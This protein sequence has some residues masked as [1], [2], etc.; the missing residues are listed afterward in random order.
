MRAGAATPSEITALG[1]RSHSTHAGVARP[2]IAA[3]VAFSLMILFVATLL[4][5][6]FDRL[7]AVDLGFQPDRLALL[8]VETR[9]RLEPAEAR[10]LQRQLLARV[11]QL[12]EVERASM[13]MW[14]LFRGWSSGGN[15]DVPG[16]G[17]V[18]FHRLSV[19]PQF[20]QAMGTRLID[21]R[22]F[23][24]RDSDAVNPVPVIVNE[25]FA[26]KFL[27][28]GIAVG[29][30]LQT[31]ISGQPVT[32][33]IVGLVGDVRDGAVRGEMKPFVF[34]PLADA[35]GTLVVRSS[36]DVRTVADRVRAELPRIHPSLRLV[37][38]TTQNALVGSTLLRERLLAVLSAFFA[39]LGLALA[40]VGLYG[41]SSHAVLRRTRE[42]GIRV[43][44]GARPAAILRS[45]LGRV[46]V[47]VA[48]GTVV[49]LAGGL[50]FA[51]F[52]GTLLYEVE[53]L[54]ASSLALPALCLTIVAFVA[55]WPPARRAMRVDPTEALRME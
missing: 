50:Y 38:V 9:D 30:A 13:S 28:G 53:P 3:Q 35:G 14:A 8:S 26:R 19:A 22:G 31:T 11:Q 47:A 4:L 44:L 15:A 32:Y 54:S 34:S 45:V 24:P 5:R 2:L 7:L 27:G 55:A 1:D 42:I 21:G 20:F 23:E 46:G 37:D 39:A 43:T 52:V 18:Q 17:R 40:A 16:R 29:S 51:R 12:P 48:A 41:V 25:A 49:G 6:S 36:L 33:D 10:E